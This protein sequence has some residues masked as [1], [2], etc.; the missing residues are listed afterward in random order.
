MSRSEK[1]ILIK[2]EPDILVE[3]L[4]AIMQARGY[5]RLAI[6]TISEDFSPILYEEGGP[7]A[8]VLSPPRNEWT[9]CFTSLFVEDE[10]ELAESLA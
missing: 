10:W 9:S 2:A 7:L 1:L 6:Q 4:D 8:F 5:E 3:A